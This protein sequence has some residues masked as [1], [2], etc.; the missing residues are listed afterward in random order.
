MQRKISVIKGSKILMILD[1]VIFQILHKFVVGVGAL[2]E[3]AFVCV[4]FVV[5]VDAFDNH[6]QLILSFKGSCYAPPVCCWWK[7]E[8]VRL[9]I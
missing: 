4:S 1:A 2:N 8:L 3:F 9:S 7:R 6:N 5:S